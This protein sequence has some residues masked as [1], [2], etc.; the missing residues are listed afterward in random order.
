MV[1]ERLRTLPKRPGVYLFKGDDGEILYV[2]KAKSL[3]TRVRSYFR[4]GEAHGLKTRELV[5]RIADLE[6]IVVGSEAEALIL[7]ANLIKEHRPRFNI[8][9]RDDKRYPHIKV[10]AQED[11]PRVFVT[12]RVVNDGAR[13]F[14][15][16]TAVG[17]LRQALEV[18]KRLYTVRSCRYD[19]LREAPPRPCLD[20]HIGRCKAPCVGLQS[21]EDYRAMTDEIL[22]ILGGEVEAVR[23]QVEARMHDA[24]TRLEFEEAG[25]LRDV[26]QGLDT[27]A[28]E[29]R[30]DR[31]AGGD[32][33][34]VGLARDGDMGAAIVFRIRK[35]TLLGRD[36]VRFADLADEDESDLLAALASRYYL[37]RGDLGMSDLP[38]EILLPREF[39]GMETLGD[40]LSEGSGRKVSVRVPQRGEKRRLV[41]LAS[42]NARHVLEDR[43]VNM[44]FHGSRAD[45]GL[46]GLQEALDLKVVPRVIVCFDIS[47]IQGADTVASAV[48]FENGEPRKGEYRHMRIR[49]D[50]GNDDF[51]SMQEAV[52][53]Y[54]ARR[55]KEERPLPD[56]VLV[57]GGKG[58]LSSAR[59]ALGALDLDH[60]AV[61]AL[62]KKDEE[63]FLPSRAAA[64]RM[65]PRDPALHLVQRL[66][67][68][69]H[70]FA[71]SYNRKLRSRRTL[72]SEL[73]QVPGV[74]PGRQKVLLTRFGSVKGVREATV[75]DIARVPGFSVTL[76]NRIKA[77]LG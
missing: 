9:L 29:Q 26:L 53:R 72:E 77:Y 5:R 42:E 14:G 71:V 46:Y 76:A 47:H 33:D 59:A 39:E 1:E 70:R 73:S 11:F 21:R 24:A 13:Y 19:L 35:G 56:L 62:A 49:G 37:G 43:M 34:V 61:A 60:V 6:T 40:V 48:V 65:T 51:R 3:R 27:L 64:V 17:P 38:R 75:E 16:F 36:A 25:R 2:G 52:G 28:R 63:I 8:Q 23:A 30:V 66:R 67:D 58:Q 57:D 55:V 45:A 31:V 69:A 44:E 4:G 22:K 68:E 18:I 54:L 32:E 74:G 20:Y 12:R 41:G 7:E 10:T 15:P 50:W